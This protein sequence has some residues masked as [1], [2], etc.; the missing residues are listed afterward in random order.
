[1]TVRALAQED[2]EGQDRKEHIMRSL[3]T[4]AALSISV[5]LTMGFTAES[6]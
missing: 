3:I 5:A 6:Y 1:L 4:V 2:T